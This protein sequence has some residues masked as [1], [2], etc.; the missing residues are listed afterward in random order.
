MSELRSR[1]R[2]ETR[3]RIVEAVLGVLVD[4]DPA[5]IDMSAVADAAGVSLRTLYR[6]FPSKA[7]L[8]EAAGAWFDLDRWASDA[9][10]ERI[11]QT[12]FA[13]YQRIRF[14]DFARNL[15]GVLAQVSTPTGRAVRRSRVPGHR[16]YVAEALSAAGLGLDDDDLARLGDAL[17]AVT[18][19]A[20]FVEL[21]DRLDLRHEVAADLTAWMVEAM[22]AH[23][24]TTTS[25]RPTDHNEVTS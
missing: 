17:I 13:A 21:V 6:Y 8:L 24:A 18:S 16:R 19:S 7:E 1:Q 2:E 12:N 23:A 9:G 10:A 25:I 5:V 3:A 15:P 20:M 11:D 14:A 4:T 22:L